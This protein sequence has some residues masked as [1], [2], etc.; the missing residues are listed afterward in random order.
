MNY[1]RKKNIMG[2]VLKEEFNYN[3]ARMKFIIMY[4][5]ERKFF[6]FFFVIQSFRTRIKHLRC[7]ALYYNLNFAKRKICGNFLRLDFQFSW[8]RKIAA[9]NP[10][11][12]QIC[13]LRYNC[14]LH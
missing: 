9:L 11:H 7:K 1:L 4:Y 2:F 10:Y 13:N 3:F 8:I 6:L 14:D 5:F 12:M